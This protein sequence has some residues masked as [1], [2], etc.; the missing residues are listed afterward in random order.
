MSMHNLIESWSYM[1]KYSENSGAQER[2]NKKLFRGT[3]HK[4]GPFQAM[5]F[6]IFKTFASD[7]FWKT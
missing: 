5:V 7:F 3:K 4:S 6:F 1:I 2:S